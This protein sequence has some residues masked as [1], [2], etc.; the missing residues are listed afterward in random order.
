MSLL[1][2][3][4]AG[5]PVLKEKAK[6]VGRVDAKLR[7]LLDDMAETMYKE[8]GIGLAAPQVGH[9][10][11]MI[12]VDVEENLLEMVNPVIIAR[13]GSEIDSEGCLSV[14]NIFGEVERSAAITVEY[15]TRFNKKRKLHADKLLARCIQ[16][17]ID[18]LDGILFIDVAQNLRQEKSEAV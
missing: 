2:I 15:V 5:A 18:H 4:K 9:S 6:A 17:E 13:S 14:P 7:R 8:N 11:R 12:V 10:L 16:H 1:K 3:E